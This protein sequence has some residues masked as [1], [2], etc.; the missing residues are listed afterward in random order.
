MV[1]LTNS[2][3]SWHAER[4]EL[5]KPSAGPRGPDCKTVPMVVPC[6]LDSYLD[7]TYPDSGV[8][9]QS[10][11]VETLEILYSTGL[12]SHLK[13]WTQGRAVVV[14]RNHKRCSGT[15]SEGKYFGMTR[16]R[17]SKPEVQAS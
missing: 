16:G 3:C 6:T 11:T 2:S 1:S 9:S 8:P 15:G 5:S 10:G 12:S 4:S 17:G 14:I 13:H 7:C